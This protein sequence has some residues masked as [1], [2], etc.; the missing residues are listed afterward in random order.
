MK[1]REPTRVLVTGAGGF[2]MSVYIVRLLSH[3]PAATVTALD[4]AP[5]DAVAEAHL[6]PVADRLEF[7]QADVR[8]AEA[9]AA[10]VAEAQPDLVVHGA[11]VTHV[12][13]WEYERPQPFIDVNVMGTLNVLVAASAA[14]VRRFI[15]VSSCAV[16]GHGDPTRSPDALQDETGPFNPADLYGVGKLGG[17][18]TARRFSELHRLPIPI[19]RF[20]RVFGPMERPTGARKVMHLPYLLAAAALT[21]RPLTISRRSADVVGD[22]IS[23]EDVAD[24]LIGL[25]MHGAPASTY[26][27]ATGRPISVAEVVRQ[28]PVEVEWVDDGTP[29]AFDADPALR[30]GQHAVYD[31]SKLTRETGW[32]PRSFAEQAKSYLDWALRNPTNFLQSA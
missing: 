5:L 3:L 4:V 20:T 15:H 9:I 6:R 8:D 29:C 13:Q 11:T 18:L 7:R 24:A 21:G 1:E 10:L 32:T 16:Y 19:V 2:V 14:M 12:P 22:W 30:R 31:V 17:E 27:V 25:S 28:F 26:N 23:A